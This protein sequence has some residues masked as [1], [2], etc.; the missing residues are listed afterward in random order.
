MKKRA[1]M[2]VFNTIWK[3]KKKEPAENYSRLICS[4]ASFAEVVLAWFATTLSKYSR[5]FAL[6]LKFLAIMPSLSVA[7][8]TLL[9][10]YLMQ[11]LNL[12]LLPKI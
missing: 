12:A 5:A 11:H 10:K 9:V 2:I 1:E 8:G 4:W 7:S 3:F 6:S